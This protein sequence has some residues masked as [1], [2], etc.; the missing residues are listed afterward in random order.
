MSSTQASTATYSMTMRERGKLRETTGQASGKNINKHIQRPIEE[1]SRELLA[2]EPHACAETNT[3]EILRG[4]GPGRQNDSGYGPC[5]DLTG[6]A[7][8]RPFSLARPLRCRACMCSR[9]AAARARAIEIISVCA[10]APA[11]AGRACSGPYIAAACRTGGGG[12]LAGRPA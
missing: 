8:V 9:P 2:C 5:R 11:P 1:H 10:R 4:G 6:I 7:R 3:G 12:G